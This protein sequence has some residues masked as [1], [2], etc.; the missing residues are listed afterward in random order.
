MGT[1]SSILYNYIYICTSLQ[2][3]SIH[4]RPGKMFKDPRRLGC[5]ALEGVYIYMQNTDM[6][7]YVWCREGPIRVYIYMYGTMHLC[8]KLH[9]PK[10]A[11]EPLSHPY[12]LEFQEHLY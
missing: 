6:H 7:V 1:Y 5:E 3:Q 11:Y 4:K 2:A 9:T 10:V 12:S 8:L